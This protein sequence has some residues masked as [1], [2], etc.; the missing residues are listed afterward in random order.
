MTVS[1]MVPGLFAA[2]YDTTGTSICQGDS[3]GPVTETLNGV[4]GI[5]GVTSFTYKGCQE[6]SGSGFVHIQYAELYGFIRAYAPDVA[7]M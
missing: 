5:V 1:E 2:S 4:T 3:G 7:V 6:G